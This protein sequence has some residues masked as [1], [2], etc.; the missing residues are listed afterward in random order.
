MWQKFTF[1]VGTTQFEDGTIKCEKKYWVQLNVTKV[2]SNMMLVLSNVTVEPSNV[3]IN[4]GTL[5]SQFKAQAQNVW[6][7]S[8][9]SPIQWICR[10][11]VKELSPNELDSS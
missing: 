2:Q 3:K 8:P 6:S 4:K 5:G 10:E 1:H 11:W 7:L 9:M